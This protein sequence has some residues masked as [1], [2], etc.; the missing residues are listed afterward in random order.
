MSG[1]PTLATGRQWVSGRDAASGREAVSAVLAAGSMSA[2]ETGNKPSRAWMAG[3]RTAEIVT[4]PT[5]RPPAM[6]PR[7]KFIMV[8]ESGV[9]RRLGGI[10]RPP[11]S[12]F[13]A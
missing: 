1:C 2:V 13:S 3:W 11:S 10:A 8:V 4:I 7:T 6:V 9:S 5:S 12:H